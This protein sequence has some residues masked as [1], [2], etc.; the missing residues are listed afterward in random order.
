MA[1]V[2]T[3]SP[4][5]QGTFTYT[6]PGSSKECVLL[7]QEKKKYIKSKHWRHADN[8]SNGISAMENSKQTAIV[9]TK[10]LAGMIWDLAVLY[11]DTFTLNIYRNSK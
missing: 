3:E 2:Y 4:N 6:L 7:Q 8:W 10:V 5:I 11:D 9:S 1:V